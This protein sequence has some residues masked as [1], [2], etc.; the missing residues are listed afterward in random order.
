MNVFRRFTTYLKPHSGYILLVLLCTGF[1]VLFST[2]SYWLAAS[3]VQ[4]LFSS[5]PIAMDQIGGSELNRWL[6]NLTAVLL[7][8]DSPTD[9]LG[10]AAFLIVVA[11]FGKNLFAYLQLYFISFV[12]QRVI[13][14]LRDELFGHIL[15]MDLAF[16][17]TQ[18]Q[19]HLVSAVLS[20]IETFNQALNRS[21]TKII[22]DPINA[23][24]LLIL[25]FA[26]S[27]KL[28]ITAI[29]VV[30][31]VGW[32]VQVVG[33]FIKRYSARVQDAMGDLTGRFL[34]TVSG[35]RII[36]GFSAENIEKLRFKNIVNQYYRSSLKRERTKRMVIPL[37]EVVGILIISSLLYVG[38]E[39]V[40]INKT[41]PSG[42]FIRFLVLL[43][44]FLNPVL[45][46][47][48]L[49]TN[50]QQAEASGERVFAVLDRKPKLLRNPDFPSPAQDFEEISFN[51]VSFRY[52]EDL[53]D[54]LQNVSFK[55]AQGEHLAIVG[56]SGSGKSTL[57]N[58]VPRFYDATE[59]SI[60]INGKSLK[61]WN[62]EGLRNLFGIVT[63]QVI[64]F[65][66]TV[67]ANIAYGREDMKDDLIRSAAKDAFA[68][69]F[70]MALPEGYNTLVGEHGAFLSGGQRQRISI[71]RSLIRDPA[72]VIFDEATSA[73]DPEAA[74]AINAAVNNLAKGRTVLNVTHR[75]A[76]AMAADRIIVLDKG[77]VI[78]EGKHSELLES[79]EVYRTMASQQQLI[80]QDSITQ[81]A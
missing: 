7:S 67:A 77:C 13:K 62:L 58:L 5:E 70:I 45:S 54:V 59:G 22:R 20:D 55:V 48:G 23:L 10:R 53:P 3:F 60:E 6:K 37:T 4:S 50:I 51:N 31:A 39:L 30:P 29:I 35:I 17:Q 46:L 42:D 28:T 56:P 57:I 18:R 16:F 14:D 1:F 79:C 26:I 38:G 11:F 36:K 49:G 9:T 78:G 73:L 33:R 81:S 63:Q 68:D 34:E 74:D 25:L 15:Q 21:F 41:I 80:N 76:G 72:I 12:E 52:D 65:H 27:P 2:A 75:L 44:A 69:D 66:N 47:A 61:D 71:A 40:L 19:G 8:G 24:V 43:F 32:V 64:L